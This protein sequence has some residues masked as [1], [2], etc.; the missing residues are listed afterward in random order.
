MTNAAAG[1]ID[2]SLEQ[3]LKKVAKEPVNLKEAQLNPLDVLDPIK[4]GL[5]ECNPEEGTVRLAVEGRRRIGR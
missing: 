3:I 1:R 4:A 5:V 2:S